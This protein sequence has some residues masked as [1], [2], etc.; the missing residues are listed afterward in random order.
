MTP[1]RD[2]ARDANG[3]WL[4]P[5]RWLDDDAVP[6]ELRRR[7]Q[8]ERAFDA[9]EMGSASKPLWAAAALRVHPRLHRELMVQGGAVDNEL[10]GVVVSDEGW[11]ASASGWRGFDDFLSLSDNRYQVRLGFLGLADADEQGRVRAGAVTGGTSESLAG[12]PA[13]PWGRFPVFPP[14]LGF[15]PDVPRRLV[16]VHTTKLATTMRELFGTGIAEGDVPTSRLSFWTG[17][18]E[19][20]A[21]GRRSS[22]AY[23]SPDPVNLRLDELKSPRDFVSVLLGG[24]GNRFSAVGHAAAF[25][26]CV[27]GAP[28]VPHVTKVREPA[29]PRPSLRDEARRLRPGLEACVSRGTATDALGREARAVL[30]ST[31]GASSYAKT[32]TLSVSETGHDT[33]RIALSVVRWKGTDRE[34]P[35]RGLTFAVVAE[36]A[37]LGLATRWLGEYVV[38]NQALIRWFLS[39]EKGR[40]QLAPRGAAKQPSAAFAAKSPRKAAARSASRPQ[41]NA[42]AKVTP[43]G[44]KGAPATRRKR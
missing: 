20:E 27:T 7:Y 18:E 25:T 11:H 43:N 24:R 39:P 33:S 37:S 17:R 3:E 13:R 30:A 4:P 12:T 42:K 28:V 9:I 29:T 41:K 21:G 15:S 22:L 40:P 23:L 8:G 36:Q 31:P 26:T 16:S 14:A 44:R 32:G 38:E 5:A 1:R 19:A 10:F 2:W 35:N 34:T 6:H